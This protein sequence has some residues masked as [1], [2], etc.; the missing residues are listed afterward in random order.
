M[1]CV[2]GDVGLVRQQGALV[3]EVVLLDELFELGL[4]VGDFLPAEF[5][6]VEWDFGLLEITQ[7]AQ[8]FGAEDEQGVTGAA[9]AASG[10]AHAVDV[11][12]VGEGVEER[13]GG[14]KGRLRNDLNSVKPQKQRM[15][16]MK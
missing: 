3:E 8:L 9:F 15:Q 11:F 13:G 12:L 6:F 16:E 10:S 2:G 5:V 7:E 1:R 4:N 14:G